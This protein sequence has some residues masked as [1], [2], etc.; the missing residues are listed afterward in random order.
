MEL[1]KCIQLQPGATTRAEVGPASSGIEAVRRASELIPDIVIMDVE[2][3]HMNG[4][5]AAQTPIISPSDA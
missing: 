4:L 3:P 2:T 5:E 1:A